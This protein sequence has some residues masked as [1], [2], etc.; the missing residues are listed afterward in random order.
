MK[1]PFLLLTLVV[2]VCV[3]VDPVFADEHTSQITAGGLISIGAGLA[4]GLAAL[5][6]GLAQGKAVASALDSIGRNP[7]ASGQL[8]IPMILGLVFMETLVIFSFVIAYY[9]QIKV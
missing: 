6:C 8:F 1:Y 4:I 5:G 2:F 9:L 7:S 3:F